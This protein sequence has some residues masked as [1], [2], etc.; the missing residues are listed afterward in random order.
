M[1]EASLTKEKVT[2]CLQA[3]VKKN[4]ELATRPQPRVI[5]PAKIFLP[6]SFFFFLAFVPIGLRSSHSATI[7]HEPRRRCHWQ[8]PQ[9]SIEG[10]LLHLPS[11]NFTFTPGPLVQIKIR[12]WWMILQRKKHVDNSP[13]FITKCFYL[14]FSGVKESLSTS[15]LN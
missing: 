10:T 4:R 12:F 3:E 6:L 15:I 11:A 8:E 5:F 7:Y 14:L 9:P 13:L 2:L 1:G